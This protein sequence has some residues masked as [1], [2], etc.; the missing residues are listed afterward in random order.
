MRQVADYSPIGAVVVLVGVALLVVSLAAAP[1][2]DFS[3]IHGPR[4]G[5]HD[6]ANMND[7]P[8]YVAIYFGWLGWLL[9][10]VTVLLACAACL[11]LHRPD[12]AGIAA[13]V[14]G[15]FGCGF[16]VAAVNRLIAAFHGAQ[17]AYGMWLMLAGFVITGIGGAVGAFARAGRPEESANGLVR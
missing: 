12:L 5:F 17:F 14:A 16:A 10:A 8:T 13:F 1:W 6:I 3:V 11:P 2:F 15:I 4:E 9:A 7:S